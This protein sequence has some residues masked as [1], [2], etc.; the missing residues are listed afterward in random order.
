MSKCS[1]N[2]GKGLEW[3]EGQVLGT[4][5]EVNSQCIGWEQRRDQ[6]KGA[7][8]LVGDV[9]GILKD[10]ASIV[11]VARVLEFRSQGAAGAGK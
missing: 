4:I 6:V 2:S 5:D 7:R 9:N 11:V 10:I 8:V 1:S 3:R